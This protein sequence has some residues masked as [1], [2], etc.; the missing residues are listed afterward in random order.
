MNTTNK[1]IKK[2]NS[3]LTTISEKDLFLKAS[4]QTLKRQPANVIKYG[5]E[6][7]DEKLI[8]IDTADLVILGA[9]TGKGKSTFMRSVARSASMQG[10]KVMY[11]ILEDNPVRTEENEIYLAVNKMR[12]LQGKKLYPYEQYVLGE[13]N[14]KTLYQ[15][16]LDLS[17]SVNMNVAKNLHWVSGKA[18]T[19][20]TEILEKMEQEK[21]NYDLFIIDHLHYIALEGKES[22]QLS[23]EY[24][25]K[26]LSK[27]VSENSLRVLMA[28]HYRKL[29]KDKPSDEAFK[30]AQAIAQNATTTIHLYP[31]EK[32]IEI[33]PMETDDGDGMIDEEY[34]TE[35]YISKT[36]N[37]FSGGKIKAKFNRQTGNYDGYKEYEERNNHSKLEL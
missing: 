29:G 18:S 2:L 10:Y 4:E 3:T 6:F 17:K 34:N 32:D 30:D 26:A 15:E 20:G 31:I 9:P 8:G 27:I 19:T 7:L 22:K 25:M 11:F 33:E 36:R 37:L 16:M 28:S 35:I 21:D 14:K 5:Y 12:E 1:I 13:I 24:F 23:V